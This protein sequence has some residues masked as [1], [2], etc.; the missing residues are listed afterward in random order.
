M[1]FVLLM[2]TMDSGDSFNGFDQFI[3]VF[4]SDVDMTTDDT[5]FLSALFNVY[6]HTIENVN[7]FMASQTFDFKDGFCGIA[8][9]LLKLAENNLR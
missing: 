8:F 6:S 9:E 1:V 3:N 2:L 5:T 4:F 7:Y